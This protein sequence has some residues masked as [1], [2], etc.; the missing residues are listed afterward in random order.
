MST[1]QADKPVHS[2]PEDSW[3]GVVAPDSRFTPEAGR[4]HLYIGLFC[5]FAHRANLVRHL[6]GLQDAIPIS[7][8][9]PYPK[10][11]DKG[12]PGWQFPGAQGP[13]DVYEG[14]TKDHLFGSKY[15]HEVY[16]KADPEYKG[17]YSVPLLWDTKENTAV[18]NESHELLR[19][20]PTAFNDILT[21]GSPEEG[22]TLCPEHLRASIDEIS[23][24][25]QRDLNT[26]VYKAGFAP[27]QDTYNKNVP[28]VFAALNHL[29]Q[30]IHKNAGPYILGNDLT[31]LDI[32]AYATIIRFDAVYVQ[33][34]KCNLGTIR[35][36]YPVIHEWMKNLYW[37]VK[38][39]KETTDFRH[40]KENYT[41]S[42]DKI[43]P[44]AITPLGPYPEVEEGVDLDF[45]RLA[46]G[47]I[48]HPAVLQR[49]KELYGQ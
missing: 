31:E 32:R 17:R 44:L 41:K 2:G 39:F 3:H 19:W 21:K 37:N 28:V 16:F 7:I 34:F 18:N 47:S 12:W 36:N 4:Y 29:E 5:P 8:V 43:N 9:K 24:W 33:H 23:E 14:A 25:M 27:D 48:K 46:P 15:L 6:K 40:I 26:G 11:D 1:V 20:L 38:G 13:D 49:Q 45:Q 22:L 42:H 35:G 10:G 30:I